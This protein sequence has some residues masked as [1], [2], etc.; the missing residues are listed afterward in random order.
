MILKIDFRKAVPGDLKKDAKSL[1]IGQTYAISRD[2][3]LTVLGIFSIQG[4]EDPFILKHYLE[5]EWILIP[6]NCPHFEEWIIESN[7]LK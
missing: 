5:K 6:E 3:G 4:N 2:N 7:L 1:K